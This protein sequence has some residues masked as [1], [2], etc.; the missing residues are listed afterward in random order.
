MKTK[1][2]PVASIHHMGGIDPM[3]ENRKGKIGQNAKSDNAY[4][5]KRHYQYSGCSDDFTFSDGTK[6]FGGS[7]QWPVITLRLS[8]QEG[9]E[10]QRDK[11]AE[12]LKQFIDKVIP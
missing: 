1:W 3:E 5:I 12:K 10:T 4:T 6:P 7:K 8:F 9:E 2:K 11:I